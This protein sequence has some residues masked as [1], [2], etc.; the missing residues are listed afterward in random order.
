MLDKHV[1]KAL[2]LLFQSPIYTHDRYTVLGSSSGL[3]VF[4]AA[5]VYAG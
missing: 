1:P 2:T 3:L 4:Y 5:L